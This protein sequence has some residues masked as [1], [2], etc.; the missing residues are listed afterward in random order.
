MGKK[1]FIWLTFP[2]HTSSFF[3]PFLNFTRY[4]L[5]LHFKC[6][7][8]SPLY[9]PSTLLPNPP[10]PSSW[11]WHSPVLGHMIFTRPKASPPIDG[12]LGHQQFLIFLIV[13]IFSLLFHRI[14]CASQKSRKAPSRVVPTF[15]SSTWMQKQ[16][17]ALSSRLAC[18]M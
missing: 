13:H 11:P 7:P 8:E 17:I 2:G 9:T 4:F 18:S 3:F 5:H 14:K 10:T 1:G 16:Q 6:Y 12:Q 15:N